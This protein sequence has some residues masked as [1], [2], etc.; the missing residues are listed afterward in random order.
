MWVMLEA[1]KKLVDRYHLSI[2]SKEGRAAK[3]IVITPLSLLSAI[4]FVYGAFLYND[5][6]EKFLS[7]IPLFVNFWYGL[8]ATPI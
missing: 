8:L 1:S 6:P 5:G 2:T 7:R 3:C 4:P